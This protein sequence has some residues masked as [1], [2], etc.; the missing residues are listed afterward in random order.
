MPFVYENRRRKGGEGG[1]KWRERENSRVEG[2][3]EGGAH[4]HGESKFYQQTW[5]RGVGGWKWERGNCLVYEHVSH[6]S[7]IQT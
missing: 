3:G 6:P 1:V 7:N 5:G 4:M 2:E